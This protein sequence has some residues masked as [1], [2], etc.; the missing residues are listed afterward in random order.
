MKEKR[1]SFACMHPYIGTIIG[2]YSPLP[3]F[4][5]YFALAICMQK[6]LKGQLAI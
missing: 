6:L 3:Q 2:L 4:Y 1:G 5:L